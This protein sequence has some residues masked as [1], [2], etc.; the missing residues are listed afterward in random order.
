MILAIWSQVDGFAGRDGEGE[1]GVVD[2]AVF[3]VAE[4]QTYLGIYDLGVVGELA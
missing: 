1:G 4:S 3:I 2:A